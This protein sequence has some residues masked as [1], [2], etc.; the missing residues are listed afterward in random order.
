MA[1]AAGERGA[2]VV[3]GARHGNGKTYRGTVVTENKSYLAYLL[4][5]EDRSAI[6]DGAG[7]TASEG[8]R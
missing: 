4:S 3:F 7:H 6:G 2:V 1:R 8:G 5:G